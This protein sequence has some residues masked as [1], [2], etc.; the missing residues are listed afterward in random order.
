MSKAFVETWVFVGFEANF[1]Q[2]IDVCLSR[3]RWDRT[4]Q[5]LD[6]GSGFVDDAEKF[7]SCF[8]SAIF[9]QALLGFIGRKPARMA[10]RFLRAYE[11]RDFTK[12]S[13]DSRLRFERLIG[14]AAVVARERNFLD[15]AMNAGFF[16]CFERGRFGVSVAGFDSTFGENPASASGLYQEKFEMA[17]ADAVANGG[18]LLAVRQNFRPGDSRCGTCTH[19]T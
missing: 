4:V 18:D 15:A 8:R 12:M 17:A 10:I 16:E 11:T 3:G 7:G 1:L 2:R 9:A 14:L 6:A 5:P 13:G 19:G